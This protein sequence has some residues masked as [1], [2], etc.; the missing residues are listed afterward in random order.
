VLV[1]DGPRAGATVTI[2]SGPG[3]KPPYQLVLDDALGLQATTYY[4]QG[5]DE[6]R[7]GYVYRTTHPE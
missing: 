6:H 3:G 7:K 5:P 4:L 2:D 1:D